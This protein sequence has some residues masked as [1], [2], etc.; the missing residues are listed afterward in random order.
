MLE[1]WWDRCRRR[2]LERLLSLWQ[3]EQLGRVDKLGLYDR[4]LQRGGAACDVSSLS[5]KEPSDT[6]GV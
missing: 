4:A 3:D 6:M 2:D 5:G 1:M